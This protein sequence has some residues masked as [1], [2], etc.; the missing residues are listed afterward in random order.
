MKKGITPVVAIVLL[1]MMT[2]A[3]AGVAYVF[4]QQMMEGTGEAMTEQAQK[5][6][7]TMQTAMTIESVSNYRIDNCGDYTAAGAAV[8]DAE[9]GCSWSGGTTTCISICDTLVAEG[10]CNAETT[11]EW[12]SDTTSCEKEDFTQIYIR[13]SGSTVITMSELTL[14]KDGILEDKFKVSQ[15]TIAARDVVALRARIDF[16]ETV[17]HENNKMVL[18]L[19]TPAGVGTTYKCMVTKDGATSC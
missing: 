5:G 9:F 10:T 6:F 12:D 19:S 18:K 13:N 15:A 16:P 7:E 1:L 2:V 11:C 8:C 3:A 4:V 17:G 14:Y